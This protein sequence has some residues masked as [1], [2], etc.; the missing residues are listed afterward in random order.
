MTTQLHLTGEP[1]RCYLADPPWNEQGAGKVKRGADRH[2]PLLRTEEIP[3]VILESGVWRPD[4]DGCHLWLWV[5]NNHLEAGLWVMRELGFRYV[6]KVTWGKHKDDSRLCVLRGD[7]LC[8]GCPSGLGR[9]F[10][11]QT[12][13]LLFGVRGRAMVPEPGSRRSTLLQSP[14]REHSSKP[15]E[16]FEVIESITPGPRI[17]LFCRGEPRP[18]WD[19]WGNQAAVA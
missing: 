15:P 2:Y 3:G 12:E 16:A 9:Y 5:T 19:A 10:T 14:R 11:G 4:D 17:E 13:D 7:R 6:N 1:Y 18:G 8:T